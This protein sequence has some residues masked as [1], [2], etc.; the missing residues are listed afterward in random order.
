MKGLEMFS[1]KGKTAI[2]TGGSGMYG[3]QITLALAEAGAKVVIASRNKDKNEEYA[4]TLREQGYNVISEELDQGNENSIK[5]LAERLKKQGDID[6]LVNNAVLRTMKDYHDDLANFNES[7]RVNATGIFAMCRV[8]GDIMAEQGKGSI[9]NIGSYMGLLGADD[10][11]YKDVG[12]SGYSAPDYF[13]HKGG[14]TNLTRFIA[15]Y[16]GP[17]GVRCNIL[18][19]GGFFNNQNSLFVERYNERTFLKRMANDTDMKGAVVFLAS[20]ASAYI[21]GAVIP[22]DGGYTAK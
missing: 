12:F 10:T 2:V 18:E 16:Y 17:K 9:I 7:M 21:T 19:P 4:K 8:F 11:L 14:M 1:L 20:D 6:V 15:S 22:V 3:K 5:A 13:F